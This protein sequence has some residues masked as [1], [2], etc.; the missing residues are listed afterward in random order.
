MYET[1]YKHRKKEHHLSLFNQT[2][3]FMKVYIKNTKCTGTA[4]LKFESQ[5]CRVN[6]GR[7]IHDFKAYHVPNDSLNKEFKYL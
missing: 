6:L 1:D 7:V 2:R 5:K 4:G 3:K